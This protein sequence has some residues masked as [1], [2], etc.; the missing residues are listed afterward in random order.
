MGSLSYQCLKKGPS[1]GTINIFA[2]ELEKD[3]ASIFIKCESGP[4]DGGITTVVD[5]Q[6]W[7]QKESDR[8]KE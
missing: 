6:F 3:A 2:Y 4:W 1:L 8:V 7:I 5:D